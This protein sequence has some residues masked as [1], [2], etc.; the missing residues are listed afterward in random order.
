MIITHLK[1][2]W[3]NFWKNKTQSTIN[4]GGLAIGIASSLLLLSYVSFQYSYDR[5]YTN[6]RSIDRVNLDY[7]KDKQLVFATAETYSAVGPALQRDFPEILLQ[8]RLYN[9]GYK[10]NCVFSY[11][12]NYFTETKFLYA[13][14][15]F[16]TLF[17]FPFLKGNPQSALTQPYTAVIS[18]STARR[19]FGSQGVQTALGKSMLMTDD[20]RNKELCKITGVF[21]DIPE[22]SHLKFNVLISYP[23]LYQRNDGL[24]R[25]EHDWNKK[26][27]YT[28]VEL[29]PGTDPKKLAAKLSSFIQ[30]H[31][32][33]ESGRGE[34]SR[35]SLQP[36][37]KIHTGAPRLDEPEPTVNE[38]TLQFLMIIAFFII[39]IAWINYINLATAGSVNRARE[40][41]VRKV[42]G[43]QRSGLIAQFLTES[44]CLNL[45]SCGLAFILIYALDPIL[46]IAFPIDF[47]FAVL[48]TNTAGWLFL[49]FLLTGA[50]L[51]GLYPALVL[52]SFKP[53]A[54][55]KGKM[56]AMGKG[57]T[58][59]RTLVVFQ[60]SLSILLIIGTIVV[61]EQ[62]HFMLNRD[63]GIK[64]S[65]VMVLP[66]PGRW[67]S[68]RSTHNLLVQRFKE[69]VE[70]DP[71]VEAI[72]MSDE[73]PGKEIR[74][75][76]NYMPTQTTLAHAIPIN[77][78]TIDQDYIPALGMSILAGRNFS[79]SYKT[80][81]RALIL[82]TSAARQ[83]GYAD[84]AGA[85]GKQFHSDDGDYTVVGIVNDFH[86]LSLQ[87]ELT[88][89]AFQFNAG[90]MRE[91]EF[92][93]VKLKTSRLHEAV[94]HIETAW[95]NNFKDNPFN[96]TFLDDFFN[97]QYQTEIQFG[98]VFGIFS[99]LAILIACTGLFALLSFTIRQRTREIG[100]RK[101]LGASL[102]D[103][104]QLLAKDF[105]RL[106]L[107]ANLIAWPLGWWLMN[108]WLKDFAYRIS[109]Q[110]P[111]FFVAGCLALLI[112]LVTICFQT[113]KAALA[114][115]IKSLR[116][117]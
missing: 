101:I 102:R 2:A 81:R 77:T 90:D 68:A 107:I 59:R 10:N 113:V 35:L 32:P 104:F 69:A 47:S 20:D 109:I 1:I 85:L 71:A 82:T 24:R 76:A 16:F 89:A 42:L 15:G 115:P 93:L 31:I 72:G 37:E 78:T 74:W 27:F 106:V 8:V 108:N 30:R 57:L 88:P 29:R 84:Y 4:M 86:Q 111:V 39:S 40:I 98:A 73:L 13:D 87:K 22:N 45:L 79:L 38:T 105:V 64:V 67:D 28:Y 33:D 54:V 66:R 46:K 23:T 52:S 60:F 92:Y 117:E 95:K 65:Q 21:R 94:K 51:S 18:E 83:L 110:W 49:L 63:L 99:L 96:F 7:Y 80:D 112:A 100:V 50:F 53:V 97:R 56:P 34:E 43:S 62:V 19:L 11:Q 6:K 61:F 48:F 114:N 44:L 25:F 3:R 58:L 12:D 103:V 75:P 36:L 17:S 14:P 41:G 55:L 116:S 26:D 9:M 70:S 5:F 91:F